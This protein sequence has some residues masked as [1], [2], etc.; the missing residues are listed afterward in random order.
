VGVVDPR[1]IQELSG[2]I[3][4]LSFDG[5]RTIAGTD[6]NDDLELEAVTRQIPK[7]IEDLPFKES[8]KE[9]HSVIVRDS[10]QYRLFVGDGSEADSMAKGLLGGIRLGSTG[11]LSLEWFKLK[12]INAASSD[13]TQYQNVEYVFHGGFDGYV[14][15]QEVGTS[16]D[17]GDID[18]LIRFPYWTLNDPE[19][20]KVLYKGKVYIDG[21]AAIQPTLSYLYNYNE[22]GTIQPPAIPLTSGAAGFSAYGTGIFGTATY[23]VDFPTI[24]D[25]NLIGSGDNVSFA[26]SSND[27]LDRYSVQ[28]MTIEY[29]LASRR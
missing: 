17:T 12:E 21:Q 25:Q 26:I 23:G 16:F 20:R 29:G 2:D 8:G 27:T 24:T 15:R 1:T 3:Y 7:T 28:S 4:Y 6:R 14:Y 19:I 11:N 10:S 22:S 18:A 5:V 9:V 13:S